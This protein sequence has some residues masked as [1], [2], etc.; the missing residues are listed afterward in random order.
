M[1]RLDGFE[2]TAA[3]R[4]RA[5][6]DA[7]PP[8]IVALTAGAMPEERARCLAAGMQDFLTKPL[9]PAEL[10]RVLD[11]WAPLAAAARPEADGPAPAVCVANQQH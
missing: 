8:P 7:P 5:R 3:I 1:P 4:A 6:P 2:A 11:T 10:R 9:L